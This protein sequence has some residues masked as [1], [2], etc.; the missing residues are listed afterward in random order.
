MRMV[1]PHICCGRY[2]F[3]LPSPNLAGSTRNEV[4]RGRNREDDSRAPPKLNQGLRLNNPQV[5]I[6]TRPRVMSALYSNKIDLNGLFTFPANF[7]PGSLGQNR[8]G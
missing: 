6:S 8:L 5:L 1:S 7:S 4:V 3:L 2:L